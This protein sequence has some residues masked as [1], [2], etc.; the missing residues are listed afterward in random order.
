MEKR[1]SPEMKSVILAATL[2]V[3]A[4][5]GAS[6]IRKRK[7]GHTISLTVDDYFTHTTFPYPM[8]WMAHAELAGAVKIRNFFADNFRI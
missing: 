3:L 5:T 2:G 8:K 1:S 7:T 6:W 4:V